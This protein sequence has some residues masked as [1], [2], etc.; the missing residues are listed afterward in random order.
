MKQTC[1]IVGYSDYEGMGEYYAFYKKEDA[2]KVMNTEFD[3]T[4]AELRS[5]GRPVETMVDDFMLHKEIYV[6]NTGIYY[7]WNVEEST[8][9]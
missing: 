2:I 1:Y 6:P 4:I 7:E 8:I 3:N 5:Q 9:E